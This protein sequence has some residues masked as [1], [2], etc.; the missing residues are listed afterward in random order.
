LQDVRRGGLSALLTAYAAEGEGI[1]V[2]DAVEERDLTLIAQAACAGSGINA[3]N[4]IIWFLA[5]H[6]IGKFARGFQ[7]YAEFPNSPLVSP[8]SG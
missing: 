1:I 4:W 2:V 3:E 5:S 8:V 6:D 7:K